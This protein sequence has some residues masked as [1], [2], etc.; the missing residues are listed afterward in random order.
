MDVAGSDLAADTAFDAVVTSSDEAGNTITSTGSSTHTVDTSSY[1]QIDIDRITSD[2]VI[3]AE[4]SEDG[5]Y[6]SITGWV[7]NDAQ[8]GDIITVT[9]DGE[10]IGQ[11]VVS[12]ELNDDGKYL[13]SVDVLGS[14]L[15]NTTMINPELVVTV[16]GED[17]AGNP[18]S[19]QSTEPYKVDMFADVYVELSE[20][21]GDA[22]IN[23]DESLTVSG[24]VEQGGDVTSITVTD[25]SGQVITITEG[26]TVDGNGDYTFNIDVSTLDDGNLTVVVN[27]TDAY[28]NTT[29]QTSIIDK[30]TSA[31]AGTV[32]VDDITSDDVINASEAG[33]TITVT[34]SAEGGDIASGDTVTLEINGETYTTTV[35]E[36][37]TWSVDVAGSD[38]VADTEFDVVVS[39]TDA[40]GNTVESS[41]S[42]SHS[43]ITSVDA[44]SITF[45]SDEDENGI[46]TS[47]ETTGMVAFTVALP[48]NLVA[49]STLE[50]D[51]NGETQ[52]IIISENQANAGV[53]ELETESLEGG[54]T[55][56]VNA[57]ITDIYGNTSTTSTS[58]V[59]MYDAPIID[60]TAASLSEESLSESDVVTVTES[61]SVSGSSEVTVTLN[62]PEEALT[63]NGVDIVWSG[64]GT[65]TLIGTANGEEVI[66][67]EVSDAVDGSGTYTTTLSG[68][69][70]HTG[71]DDDTLSIDVELVVNDGLDTT[72]ESL[73]VN[74]VDS[75]PDAAT[76]TA[77]LTLSS[78]ASTF[79][80]AS[81]TSGF[82]DTEFKDGSEKFGTSSAVDTDSD[83]YD[84]VLSWGNNDGYVKNNGSKTQVYDAG[85]SS[86]E[87]REV[88]VSSDI[89]F[90]DSTVVA[91]ITHT[92]DGLVGTYA[93]QTVADSFDS[94][95][96]NVDVTMIIDGQEITVTLSSS[97]TE[98]ETSNDLVDS[99]DSLTLDSSS[100]TVEVNG[101]S[102]TVYLDGF[103]V[104]GEIVNTVTTAEEASVTYSVAAHVELTDTTT[105]QEEYV[106]T[107]TLET[108]AG[109]D[110]LDSVVEATTID[111]N[112]TLVVNEDG[113]YSFTPSD[114]LVA[115]I[116]STDSETVEYTYSV[117]DGDGDTV[118]N[119]LSITVTGS[120]YGNTA[121]Q[122]VDD[123]SS[124]I[125]SIS[126]LNANFYN[127]D[128]ELSGNLTDIAAAR[129]VIATQ[130]ANA[131]WVAT[132]INYQEEWNDLGGE[133]NL[134]TW[135][136]DDAE[137]LVYYDEQ[138]SGDAV[139]ELTGSVYLDAGSY[140]IK[141]E[142]DDGY[143]IIINGEIVASVD[144][145]QSS[146]TNTFTFDVSDA[147]NQTIEI[148]YW[149]QGGAYEL[150]ISL[151]EAGTNNYETLGSDSYPTFSS[152]S[153]DFLD[154][155]SNQ[156]INISLDDLLANDIDADGDE[157]S[158]TSISNIT[159]GYAY[160]NSDGGII[161]IPT[162]GFSGVA[163]FDYTITDGN[164]GYSTA[165]A[166]IDVADTGVLLPTVTVTVSEGVENI[167]SSDSESWT[168]FSE[169]ESY[170]H[171][172]NGD[173][174][175]WVGFTGDS[176]NVYIEDDVKAYLDTKDGDDQVVIGDDIYSSGGIQLGAGDDKLLVRDDVNGSVDAG[177]GDDEIVVGGDVTQSMTL[178]EGNNT[179]SV[180]GTVSANVNAGSGDD[181]VSVSGDVTQSMGLGD[182]D[183]KLSVEGSVSGAINTGSGM[184]D[185]YIAGDANAYIG[186]SAGDDTLTVDGDVGSN[187]TIQ[188]GSGD[189]F[190]VIKGNLNSNAYLDGGND[191]DSIVLEN[192][193]VDQ[194]NLD[195]DNIKTRVV[196]FENIMVGG[197]VVAGDA[198]AFADYLTSDN[199]SSTETTTSNYSYA[200]TV[201]IDNT[202]AT[203]GSTI[204]SLFG[205]PTTASLVLDGETLEANS[206]GSYSIEVAAG[207][208]S[209]EGLSIESDVELLDLDVTSQVTSNLDD[210]ADIVNDSYLEG[211][212]G[213]DTLV[214]DLGDDVL[215]GGDDEVS[216][217]L[218][219]ADGSDVFILNDV[220]DQTN[221]DTIVDFNASEDALDLTD[222]L[223]GIQGSPG[224]DADADDIMAFLNEHVEVKDGSVKVDDEDVADFTDAT[225]SFDS[226]GDGAVNSVDSIKVIYN[227]EEYSINI[228]G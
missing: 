42:S 139:V 70:D 146:A 170:D 206:N 95:L 157:L 194:Y 158:V 132:E 126:G 66:R 186:T 28:G 189:D 63:S 159:N 142:A 145:N 99:G 217:I 88:N 21:S 86:V 54:E 4:E 130:S 125:S 223:T 114:V 199:T 39:S 104:D 36:G 43:V 100:A 27:A 78:V 94:A 113:T 119:T 136:G 7:G 16:T 187:I 219:G 120:N 19:T 96:F 216:D 156:A 41:G 58:T 127:Y 172:D 51:I 165:T 117:L 197:V 138:T 205:I 61:Y 91:S 140:D 60:V 178:G 151:A 147:G 168:G 6:V 175:Q 198:A 29:S 82:S 184:D 8:P 81:I 1:G 144:Y 143:E 68:A 106:L 14:D 62:E 150:N 153:D 64:E 212:D 177:T 163:T 79:S 162:S 164:G 171:Y 84:E 53:V 89:G 30:D 111:D 133:G 148:I 103:L 193:T 201:D 118:E 44:P 192:Y 92:N 26:I 18:F 227:N 211:T 72:T 3:N 124:D 182:G 23:S 9:L 173:Y 107:G 221:I 31:D 185:I 181:S 228:D 46:I 69:I 15:A 209:I 40:A 195:I 83:S 149:D 115:T 57:T 169:G 135:I 131:S 20:E 116:G 24:F 77:T 50:I 174:D 166:S 48:A 35:A 10:V 167:S 225:S 74:V 154:T 204:V 32:T 123:S 196:N 226:N 160:L 22:V 59:E 129:A 110:G 121:P 11:G 97:F 49:G 108:D 161:F 67:I 33:S 101:A 102:Y 105:I 188:T 90:G 80:I 55:I 5:N 141:V 155:S 52:T 45:T 202:D 191:T 134:A 112:G 207:E 65:D 213:L 75:T 215:F 152:P 222:L 73:T 56:T 128:Q 214:G 76:T 210:V 208:T 176:E 47:S 17:D 13:Y 98:I 38:L 190:V 85:E 2:G 218:T 37:G 180:G 220:A 109:A 71:S 183:N 12:S 34:G 25:E 200:V 179:L 87:A 224:K 122:A 137:S 203:A 93:G